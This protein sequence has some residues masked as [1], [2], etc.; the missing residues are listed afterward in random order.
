M[1]RIISM[2]LLSIENA[3]LVPNEDHFKNQL[4]GIYDSLKT[5]FPKS[6][7]LEEKGRKEKSKSMLQHL[8]ALPKRIQ[9]LIDNAKGIN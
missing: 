5:V 2:C 7:P 3:L 9:I 4:N 6:M 1:E 8:Q